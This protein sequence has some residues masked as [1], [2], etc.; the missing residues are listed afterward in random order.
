MRITA[1]TSKDATHFVATFTINFLFIFFLLWMAAGTFYAPWS[2]TS[3]KTQTII[4]TLV[5]R[6]VGLMRRRCDISLVF[7]FQA[8]LHRKLLKGD[9]GQQAVCPPSPQYKVMHKQED[10]Q[11]QQHTN[12]V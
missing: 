6:N 9:R 10:G 2:W 1:S 5:L 7:I 3:S 4:T 11:L 8:I 12:H